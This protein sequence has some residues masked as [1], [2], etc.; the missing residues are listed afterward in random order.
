MLY[1]VM[2]SLKNERLE[3]L[4][5]PSNQPPCPSIV[6]VTSSMYLSSNRR[7]SKVRIKDTSIVKN[8][9][10]STTPLVIMEEEEEDVPNASALRSCRQR[11]PL[12][13]RREYLGM[14]GHSWQSLFVA[15]QLICT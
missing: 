3:I 10:V 7:A 1:C 5:H 15:R 12:Q 6:R 13:L 8:R 11:H 4:C 9:T 14:P 2:L